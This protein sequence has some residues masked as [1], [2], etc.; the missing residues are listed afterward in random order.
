MNR[1]ESLIQ[2]LVLVTIPGYGKVR[3]CVRWQDDA[4]RVFIL[5][6]IL[7][8][9]REC[10][11][12]REFPNALRFAQEEVGRA[13][14][15]DGRPVPW[16]PETYREKFLRALALKQIRDAEAIRA[17]LAQRVIL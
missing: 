9:G 17:R 4:W 14:E 13:L 16:K 10:A 6:G 11:T 5:G 3:V 15:G 1:S 12:F 2:A 7:T 8:D